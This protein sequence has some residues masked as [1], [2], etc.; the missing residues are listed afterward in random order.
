[1][2]TMSLDALWNE[3]LGDDAHITDTF[4]K[5]L[6]YASTT[7]LFGPD[8]QSK[9]TQLGTM[10]LLYNLKENFGLLNSCFSTILR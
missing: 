1:M 9:S 8:D 2:E 3:E 4:F 6:K 5:I 7:L 10:M